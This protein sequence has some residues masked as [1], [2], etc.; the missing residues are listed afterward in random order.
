MTIEDS[1][2][3]EAAGLVYGPRGELYDHP[4]DDY[5]RTVRIFNALTGIDLT[6]EQG[7]LFMLAM[8]LSRNVYA[9]LTNKPL[10]QRR[11]SI[12]DTAGYLDCYWQIL[13]RKQQCQQRNESRMRYVVL[14]GDLMPLTESYAQ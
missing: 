10:E 14:N 2:L 8:K 7:V 9:D 6:P 5:E 1:I 11:D 4:A 12:V 3:T 13:E